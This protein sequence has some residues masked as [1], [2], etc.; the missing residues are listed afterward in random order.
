MAQNSGDLGPSRDPSKTPGKPAIFVL[1]F[2]PGSARLGWAALEIYPALRHAA[3]GVLAVDLASGDIGL[4]RLR[5]DVGALLVRLAP[6]RVA[7]E[8]VARV[9]QAPGH[10][11]PGMATGL[12]LAAWVAGEVAG[13]A[14]SRGLEVRTATREQARR[15]L[16]LAGSATDAA[17][18]LAVRS[19][20]VDWPKRS[21]EHARDAAA[22]AMLAAAWAEPCSGLPAVMDAA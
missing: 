2:D 12:V 10:F 18:S 3:S 16:G 9:H 6:D 22:L 17:V 11:G 20:V 19:R 7:I 5:A 21:T 8:R 13:L 1:G 15:A 4:A 14:A